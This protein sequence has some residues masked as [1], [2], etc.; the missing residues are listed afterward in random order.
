MTQEQAQ[1]IKNILLQIRG[2]IPSNLVDPI[3]SHY[4]THINPGFARPCT[5]QPKYWNQMIMELKDKVELVLNKV[6]NEDEQKDYAPDSNAGNK[7][8]KKS[9]SGGA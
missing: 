8:R 2:N 6:T 3:Y 7:K 4:K 9:K 5:C 1:E